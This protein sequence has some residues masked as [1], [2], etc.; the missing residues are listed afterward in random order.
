MRALEKIMTVDVQTK[1]DKSLNHKNGIPA[2]VGNKAC[3]NFAIFRHKTCID[4][5]L[6]GTASNT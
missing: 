2:Y 4:I 5:S 6:S 1:N 3:R